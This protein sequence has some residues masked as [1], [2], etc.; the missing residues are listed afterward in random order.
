MNPMKTKLLY[1][2]IL[3]FLCLASATS[4]V[5]ELAVVDNSF[6]FVADVT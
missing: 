5:N 4:C 1:I 6:E 2:I 3:S